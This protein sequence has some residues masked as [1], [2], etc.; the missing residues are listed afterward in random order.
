MTRA[1]Y[2]SSRLQGFGTTVFAEMSALAVATGSVNL[3]QGF[4]DYPGPPE[5][6]DVA[7]AA[8]GTAADQYPPGPG[9]PELRDAIAAHVQRFRGL[10][11]DPADEVLVTAGATEA[12]SGALLALLD[13]G[14]EVVLFEPMYDCYAAGIAMAGGTARPVPLRPPTDGAGPWTFDPAEVRAAIT[15]RTRILLLNTPH[16]PTGKV[17]TDEELRCLADLADANDLIVLTDEVYEHLVFSGAAHRSIAALPGMRERTLVVGSA[18]KTFNVTGWKIGWICGA[19]PLVS[20]V[21]TA[22]QF[23][24]YV[25]GGPFQPAVAAGLALPD[26]YFEHAARDL[27]YRRDVLV[28]GLTEGGLP[29]ISPEATY[30]ATVDVRPVQPDGDG[31][32]FCR[33]LPERAGVVAVPTVVFYDPA[34]AHLGRHLVRFAFCKRDEVLAEAVERLRRLT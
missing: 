26:E 6:L 22:K 32:A 23:L 30:F 28:Q 10:A 5:V 11:Y 4:P 25:N 19:A 33:S 2:L 34:H 3:G 14:D 8:I 15:P 7:R 29:V 17:F 9:R 1:P 31:L 21:R 12:L 27:E 20:A 16:N 24:T 18:G 13:T